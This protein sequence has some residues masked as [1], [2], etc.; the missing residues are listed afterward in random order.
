LDTGAEAVVAG[1]PGC[2]LQISA[3]TEHLG[4]PLPVVHP[5]E[6]LARSIC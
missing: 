4:R 6:L 1:N 3:H 5:M 2:A